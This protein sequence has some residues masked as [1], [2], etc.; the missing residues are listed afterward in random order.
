MA[1]GRHREIGD[2]SFQ[3]AVE[4]GDGERGVAVLGLVEQAFLDQL[5]PD[6]SALLGGSVEDSGHGGGPLR[7]GAEFGHRPQVRP[8]EFGGAVEPDPEEVGVELVLHDQTRLLRVAISISMATQSRSAAIRPNSVSSTVLPTPRN[9]VM[10]MDC[11]VRPA[12]RRSS[13]TSNASISPRRPTSTGGMA[14]ALGV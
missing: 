2:G 1:D 13:S 4:V 8:L 14:P 6:G 3:V 7:S 5:G 12:R 9:P 11:S 10:I